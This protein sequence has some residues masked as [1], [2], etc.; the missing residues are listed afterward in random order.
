MFYSYVII[1]KKTKKTQ[2]NICLSHALL[3]L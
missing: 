2:N 3:V 1:E